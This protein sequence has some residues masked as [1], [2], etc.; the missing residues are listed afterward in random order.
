MLVTITI[1]FLSANGPIVNAQGIVGDHPG[2]LQECQE[3]I[4]KIA[5][6]VSTDLN[7]NLWGETYQS[8][9]STIMFCTQAE[10][11]DATSS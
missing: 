10:H 3:A 9:G 7:G 4:L 6:D 2:A 8:N 1:I 5:E 11:I